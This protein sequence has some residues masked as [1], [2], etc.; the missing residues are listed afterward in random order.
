M[1]ALALVLSLSLLL[2]ACGSASTLPG[3]AAVPARFSRSSQA[4]V[5]QTGYHSTAVLRIPRADQIP[6][7]LAALRSLQ[8]QTR[9]EP[10]NQAFL[11]HQ[12]Q[13]DPQTILIWEAFDSEAAFQQ[14]LQSPHLQGFLQT[15]LVS[16]VQGFSAIRPVSPLPARPEG[17]FSTAVLKLRPGQQPEQARQALAELEARTRQEAGA[18]TFVVFSVQ[19]DGQP[20][21]VIWEC[22]ENEAAFQAHLKSAHLQAFLGLNLVSFEKGYTLQP[23]D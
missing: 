17:Y 18:R 1:K 8:A 7:A 15:K 14:H 10:G 2:S 3:S 9:T 20:A 21:F 23:I 11:V 6:Q 19:A 12:D 22:F 13:Q 5:Q 16:F 4:R